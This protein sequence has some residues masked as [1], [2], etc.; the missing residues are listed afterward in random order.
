MVVTMEDVL[1]QVFAVAISDI[2]ARLVMK[3]R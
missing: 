1:D 2:V 3:V